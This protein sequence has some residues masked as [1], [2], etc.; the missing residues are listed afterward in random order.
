MYD[1]T[2]IYIDLSKLHIETIMPHYKLV[3]EWNNL[4]N[5]K[6]I[7]VM[8]GNVIVKKKMFN[9]FNSIS[10]KNFDSITKD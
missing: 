8:I 10:K 2:K 3:D 4:N 7:M 9:Y 1:K 6:N 5:S